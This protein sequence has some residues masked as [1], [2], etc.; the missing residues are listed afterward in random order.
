MRG[1]IRKTMK[2]GQARN[3]LAFIILLF[4]T[5]R[6][7]IT[8]SRQESISWNCY[9]LDKFCAHFGNPKSSR[10]PIMSRLHKKMFRKFSV[11]IIFN[12]VLIKAK[13][14]SGDLF[15]KKA[16]GRIR[17]HGR[18]C[19]PWIRDEKCTQTIFQCDNIYHAK[20]ISASTQAYNTLQ[21]KGSC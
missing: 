1:C 10:K 3:I 2:D 8:L 17:E 19:W 13:N 15:E 6:P 9:C 11:I 12:Y 20:L 5:E 16:K 18:H 14:E 4:I 7:Q 21:V